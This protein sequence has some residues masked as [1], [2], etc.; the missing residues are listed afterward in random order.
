[1]R[2]LLTLFTA[3]AILA[4]RMTSAQTPSDKSAHT[5]EDR[6]KPDITV[7]QDGS[8]DFKTVQDA[9][10]SIPRDNHE[11]II[12]LVKDGVYKEKVR[13]D[14]SCITLRGQSRAGT[15]IEFPQ[16]MDAF[17]QHPDDL[18]RAVLNVRGD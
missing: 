3:V 8:G 9:I 14:A 5:V 1:M 10:A 6:V 17:T 7:A 15:R 16:L 12:V 11:R 4:G 13:V 18:G 2:I